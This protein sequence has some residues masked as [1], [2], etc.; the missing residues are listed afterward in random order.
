MDKKFQFMKRVYE[1]AGKYKQIIV[2]S[3]E[4]VTSSQV[5]SI[6]RIIYKTGGTLIVGKNVMI[7]K[8]KNQTKRQLNRKEENSNFTNKRDSDN[9]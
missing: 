9:E 1:L 5:Q 8:K 6:R 3:L 2:V 7:I 4:N